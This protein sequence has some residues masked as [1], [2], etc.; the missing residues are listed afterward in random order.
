MKMNLDLFNI[1]ISNI[2]DNVNIITETISIC[3]NI[4]NPF[5]LSISLYTQKL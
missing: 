2:I 3:N 5:V 1:E 4:F